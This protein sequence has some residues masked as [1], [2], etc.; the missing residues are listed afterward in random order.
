MTPSEGSLD[1][2]SFRP[3]RAFARTR[4]VALVGSLSFCATIMLE[5]VFSTGYSVPSLNLVLETPVSYLLGP[6]LGGLLASV[7]NSVAPQMERLATTRLSTARV[8]LLFMFAI[9]EVGML[10][11]TAPCA[12]VLVG[13][14]ISR[15]EL[16][17]LTCGTVFFQGLGLIS[18]A[19]F[20]SNKVWIPLAVAMSACVLFGWSPDRVPYAWNVLLVATPGSWIAAVVTFASGLLMTASLTVGAC[21]RRRAQG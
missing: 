1:Y 18:A 20:Y 12:N 13:A 2:R 5:S 6:L 7:S 21:E 17:A 3:R 9:I 11:A 14:G 10:L 19:C 8:Q 4:R 15:S 16:A